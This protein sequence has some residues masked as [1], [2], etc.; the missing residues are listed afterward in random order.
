MFGASLQLLHFLRERE[1]ERTRLAL[2]Y[3][4]LHSSIM[5]SANDIARLLNLD[6]SDSSTLAAVISDYFAERD[7]DVYDSSSASDDEEFLD[8]ESGM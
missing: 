6:D 3:D 5:A 1:R 2:P 8:V 4:R 7:A